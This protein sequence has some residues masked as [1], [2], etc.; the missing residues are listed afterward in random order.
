MPHP[1]RDL[2]REFARRARDVRVLVIGDV[3]LDVYLDGAAFRISP[4]APVPVVRVEG[5][6]RALGG[7]ANVS[8]NVRA[9]GADCSVIACVG[10]DDAGGLLVGELRRAGIDASGLVVDPE[11][12]TSV[13]TRVLVR[14][15]Q[16][17]RYDRECDQ[18]IGPE[19]AERLVA[20]L[21]EVRGPIHAVA[22]E[23]Y[24]KGTLTGRT[25]RAAMSFA[26]ER[27]LPVVVD[28]KAR[29][30][31]AY[32]GATV[33]KPNRLELETALRETVR[34][35]DAEWLGH[36]RTRLG[37]EYLVVTLGDEGIALSAA[38]GSSRTIP[39]VAR[40]VY[41]VSGAGDTVTA[42]LATALGAGFGVGDAATLANQAAG[43]QVGKAGV[44][45]VTVEEIAAAAARRA[46]AEPAGAGRDEPENPE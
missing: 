10:A 39:T 30:F 46:R 14:G 20:A 43:V 26:R 15:H 29:N 33:F 11:R 25:I 5:E 27:S 40:S 16:V 37:C 2:V 8:A 35:L 18:E 22:I 24:D 41:D 38:D 23:D 42:V 4:E 19:V 44:A 1:P 31:F 17:A 7:A 9:L 3:M 6:R 28:P 45:T 34:P 13:K 36:A 12:P 32:E 21:A